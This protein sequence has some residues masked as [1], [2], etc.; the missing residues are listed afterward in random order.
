MRLDRRERQNMLLSLSTTHDKA[1]A[2]LDDRQDE[3][4][5]HN[6]VVEQQ[7]RSLACCKIH[8]CIRYAHV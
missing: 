4:Q 6:N 1:Q 5:E 3:I 2:E 7:A 8:P